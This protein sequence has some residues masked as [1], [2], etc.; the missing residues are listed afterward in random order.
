MQSAR[1]GRYCYGKRPLQTLMYS[2]G[3]AVEK[4]NELMFD[5]EAS[6]SEQLTDKTIV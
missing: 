4:D 3:L 1:S 6:D 2:K 5:K